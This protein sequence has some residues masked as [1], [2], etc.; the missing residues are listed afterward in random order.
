M[1]QKSSAIPTMSYVITTRNKL[2]TLR[3]VM[4][5]LL[6]NRKDDEEI[7][8]VDGGST[9]GTPEY[10]GELHDSGAIQHFLSEPDTG[11][12]HGSNKGILIARGELIKF[13][14]DDDAFYW[15]GVQACKEF[16]LAHPEVDLLGTDGAAADWSRMPEP[17]VPLDYAECFRAWANR[18]RPFAF[19]DL[20]LMV[21]RSSLPLVGLWCP[22]VVW[23]DGEFTLRATA[24]RATLAWHTGRTWVRITN[25]QSTSVTQA[26]R[27][28]L[29]GELFQ[30]LYTCL[31][32]DEF[33]GFR[34]SFRLWRL[35]ARQRRRARRSVRRRKTSGK[36][37][38][39]LADVEK[40]LPSMFA[41][42][43]DWLRGQN[44][45]RKGEFLTRQ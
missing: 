36:G 10:L 7:V 31:A 38:P 1:R 13:I 3:L 20:G 24:S 5:R 6:A 40:D 22:G 29:E 33:P 43:D 45:R 28:E 9:D 4:E 26:R 35:G 30:R 34:E 15:P 16:L 11:Q 32:K 42:A 39:G 23:L 37:P 14:N 8:I 18:S 17:F 44:E 2:P 12:A 21:R 25:P 19:C 27:I 41:L